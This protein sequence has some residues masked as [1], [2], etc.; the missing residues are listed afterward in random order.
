MNFD[1]PGIRTQ[2]LLKALPDRAIDVLILGQP[3]TFPGRALAH[4]RHKQTESCGI[5]AMSTSESSPM[6][7]L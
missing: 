5:I 3:S 2:K 1:G 6:Q 7:P 4:V